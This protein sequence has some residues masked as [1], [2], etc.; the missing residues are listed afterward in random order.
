MSKTTSKPT[1]E[2]LR[3][4]SAREEII[5]ALM[6]HQ[7]SNSEHIYVLYRRLFKHPFC[8]QKV[9]SVLIKFHNASK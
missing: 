4:M 7:Y 5:D 3:A 2:S 8:G 6:Y 1:S 9:S